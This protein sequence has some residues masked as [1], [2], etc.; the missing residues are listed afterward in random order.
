MCCGITP[1][2]F[3][4]CTRCRP[5]AW[6][7]PEQ[8]NS[9]LIRTDVWGRSGAWT[10]PPRR[11]LQV[12]SKRRGKMNNE[13][14]I[15]RHFARIGVE[16]VLVEG[17]AISIDVRRRA[18]DELFVLAMPHAAEVKLLGA[19]RADRHLLLLV[20]HRGTKSRFLCGHDE[21]HWFVAAIPEDERGVTDIAKAKA[22][23][24]PALVRTSALSL[25]SK[26]SLRRR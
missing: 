23:L 18:K 22:A 7:W 25:K 13:T 2:L 14:L 19:D 9:I 12:F 4:S 5:S 3:E 21:R 15:E 6:R 8:A 20:D 24:Q 10:R 1:A 11:S 16:A 17:E 26:H